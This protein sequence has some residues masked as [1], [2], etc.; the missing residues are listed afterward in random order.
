[1]LHL[2]NYLAPVLQCVP[3]MP[4]SVSLRLVREFMPSDGKFHKIVPQC[5]IE[6]ALL[7]MNVAACP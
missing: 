6:E 3:G 7:G 4:A 2:I 5:I 1:M